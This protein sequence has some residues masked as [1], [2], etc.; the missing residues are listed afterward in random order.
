M[1]IEIPLSKGKVTI[2]DD[3]DSDLANFKWHTS[4]S[5]YAIRWSPMK[6]W[7]R[8]VIYI[9]RVIL[10]RKL[11]RKLT[12]NEYTDHINRDE[13]D[14]RR[15]NLRAAT[16]K[17][18]QHNQGVARDN[19]SG[20]K[21]VAYA[22]NKQK[23]RA[24]INTKGRPVF[25]GLFDDAKT[26]ALAYDT[27]ARKYYGEFAFLNFPNEHYELSD[28]KT[29]VVVSRKN[30]SGYRGVSLFKT[31]NRYRA[32]IYPY[33][34]KQVNLGYFDDPIDAAKAYDEA[35]K[36]YFGDSALLNFP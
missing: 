26:A 14:N 16:P 23:W 35:A 7:E 5:G 3:I 27:Q 13:L 15:R 30:S 12:D 2:V 21:G 19:M 11:K 25:I 32:Y 22:K 18:N 33:N 17:Q 6:N 29:P 28:L 20:Y 36:K 24:A 34:R 31:R 10:E 8:H 9:H 4:S 1:T